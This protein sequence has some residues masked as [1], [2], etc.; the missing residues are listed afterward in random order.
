MVSAVAGP[1]RP[2]AVSSAH[3][4]TWYA[5]ERRRCAL[6]SGADGQRE[7]PASGSRIGS[8]NRSVRTYG[9]G[10]RWTLGAGQLNRDVLP[11]TGATG[12]EVLCKQEVRGSSPLSSTSQNATCHDARPSPRARLLIGTSILGRLQL[13]LGVRTQSIS[14]SPVP[15][16]RG[17]L[18]QQCGTGTSVPHALHQ[19]PQTRARRRPV[20]GRYVPRPLPSRDTRLGPLG[21]HE[22]RDPWG[23]EFCILQPNFPELLNR[24]RSV[25]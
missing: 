16:V 8:Q 21:R 15:L 13:L 20:E 5:S 3:A 22:L 14:D 12:P 11:R 2:N 19:L 10:R 23:N 1:T 7:G 4:R 17:V 24:R 6:G 9:T 25:G 18:I